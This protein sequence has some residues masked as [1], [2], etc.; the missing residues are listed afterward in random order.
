MLSISSYLRG[1]ATSNSVPLASTSTASL[2]SESRMSVA[3]SHQPISDIM[4]Q[5]ATVALP[6]KGGTVYCNDSHTQVYCVVYYGIMTSTNY[7][8]MVSIWSNITLLHIIVR[9]TIQWVWIISVC[10]VIL[11]FY[12][13]Y[14]FGV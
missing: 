8:Y 4:F 12:S 7:M 11:Y 13:V 2:V 6:P 5:P 14:F 1:M 3:P 10:P 9:H